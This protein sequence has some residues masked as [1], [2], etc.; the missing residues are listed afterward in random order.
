MQCLVAP[1]HA[2]HGLEVVRGIV[3]RGQG[4]CSCALFITVPQMCFRAVGCVVFLQSLD[5]TPPIPVHVLVHVA[6]A[7]PVATTPK[8]R[9][10]AHPFVRKPIA[11]S[12]LLDKGK[13]G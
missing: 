1:P 12:F 8:S 11:C 5:F 10:E 3:V 13:V 7:A 2:A 9:P 4:S 6:V